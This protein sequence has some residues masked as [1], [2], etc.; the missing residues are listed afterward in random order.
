MSNYLIKLKPVGKFFFG[1]DMTFSV[2]AKERPKDWKSKTD[3]EK[4]KIRKEIGDNARYSSYIIKSEKFS[5][6][7]SLLGM[8]RFLLLRKDSSL[9]DGKKIIG[10]KDKVIELIGE[11]SFTVNDGEELNFGK[12]KALSP[13]FILQGDNVITRLPMDYGLELI[14]LSDGNPMSYNGN[15]IILNK[16]VSGRKDN[17]EEIKYSAKDGLSVRYAGKDGKPIKEEEIFIEDQRIGISRNINTGITEENALYKQVNYCLADDFCFAFYATVDL[18]ITTKDYNNKL[19][20]LGADSSNFVIQID[21]E[22]FREISLQT[23]NVSIN[24]ACCKVVLASP[25]IIDKDIAKLADFAIAKTMP[26]KFMRRLS[27]EMY[28]GIIVYN[29]FQVIG[30]ITNK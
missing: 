4:T 19:V 26:F 11:R 8:L 3:E 20:S 7:T 23:S 21:A 2:G 29:H 24:N 18:D 5:Q 10:N 1:G 16:I 13:C 14:D 17:E 15:P 30:L 6:Q 22:D 28:S 12:I 25:T 9:F 27:R